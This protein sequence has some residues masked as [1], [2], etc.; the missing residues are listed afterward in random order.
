[1]S[2]EPLGGEPRIPTEQLVRDFLH[3]QNLEQVG[4]TDEAIPLYEG[5]VAAA[6]DAA[7]P[8]DRLIFIYQARQAHRDV[9]R[10]C[11]SSL[12]SVRTYEAKK[13][14]YRQQMEAARQALGS[15]PKPTPR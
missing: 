14:W 10:V 3:G 4:R 8:Y 6:F 2:E 12:Q 1:M 11:E 7:G 15:G 13:M 9:I 5:A